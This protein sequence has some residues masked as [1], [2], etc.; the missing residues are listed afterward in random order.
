VNI[1]LTLDTFVPSAF[2]TTRATIVGLGLAHIECRGG[3]GTW[4]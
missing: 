2:P 1:V 3:D 4:L